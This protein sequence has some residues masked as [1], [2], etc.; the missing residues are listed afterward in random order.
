METK[1]KKPPK[2]AEWILKKTL[3]GFL[4]ISALGDYE[5]IYNRILKKFTKRS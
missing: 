4:D 3:P 5:E 2:L 1:P